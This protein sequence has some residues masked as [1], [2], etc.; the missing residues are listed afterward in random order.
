LRIGGLK[1]RFTG[2]TVL[3]RTPQGD[4]EATIA[5]RCGWTWRLWMDSAQ[6][7]SEGGIRELWRSERSVEK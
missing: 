3:F 1:I 5:G 4:E 2:L 7:K 6:N